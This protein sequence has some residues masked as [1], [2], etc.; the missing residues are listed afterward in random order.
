MVFNEN[1]MSN[2][3]KIIVIG[4]GNILMSD[5]GVG[6][7]VVERLMS[8]YSFP[9]NVELYDGGTTGMQGLLPL[10]EMADHLVVIDAVKGA[11]EP[12][13]VYRYTLEDFRLTIP[14]KLSAHDIGFI[15]CLAV[16]EIN[17]TLPKSV[18]VIGIRP[19]DDSTLAMELTPTI[20]AK[21]EEL[22]K[23]TLEEISSLG[24]TALPVKE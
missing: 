23:M 10:M 17:E 6:V 4:I 1:F 9:P 11:G 3:P 22:V 24:A 14:K 16:A 13:S 15:E 12:G 19:E 18:V 21:V 8:E 5:E 20:K 7:R 2:P